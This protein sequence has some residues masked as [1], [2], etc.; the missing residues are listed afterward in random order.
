MIT[1]VFFWTSR[2]YRRKMILQ[3]LF[4][5]RKR[6]ERDSGIKTVN[7]AVDTPGIYR[8]REFKFRRRLQ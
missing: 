7:I 8:K 2:V 3:L 6:L 1:S 5:K 4:L